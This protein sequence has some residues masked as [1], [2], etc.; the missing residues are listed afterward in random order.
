MIYAVIDTNVVV[1]ALITKHN[2]AATYKVL[3]H[4]VQG[5]VVPLYND[6][7]IS[8]YKEVLSRGKFHLT[9]MEIERVIGYFYSYG[10]MMS[11]SSFDGF[12]PDESDRVFYEVSLSKE[13]SFLVTGNLKHYPVAPKVVSPSEFI[14]IV[15]F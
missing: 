13:D 5:E 2:D 9:K 15:G 10:I 8:E 11:K 14:R 12:M 7:I 4:I 1:S 3:T 6:E